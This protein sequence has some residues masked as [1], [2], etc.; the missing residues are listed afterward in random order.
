MRKTLQGV[1]ARLRGLAQQAARA[2][3]PRQ[4]SPVYARVP[5]PVRPSVRRR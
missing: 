4:S 1:I 5:V 3:T 2:L